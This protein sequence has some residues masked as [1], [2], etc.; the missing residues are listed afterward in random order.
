MFALT[1]VSIEKALIDIVILKENIK[2]CFVSEI[3]CTTN[4]YK[5]KKRILV[6]ILLHNNQIL[7]TVVLIII[8]T[9]KFDMFRSP[10]GTVLAKVNFRCTMKL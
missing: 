8:F 5:S 4:I 2:M 7:D 6:V 3:S 1:T 9:G 10:S